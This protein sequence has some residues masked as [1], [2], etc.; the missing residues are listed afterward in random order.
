MDGL[1]D[2]GLRHSYTGKGD[3]ILREFLLP[4]LAVA[5]RYDRITSY[6]TIESLLAIS[7]GIQSLHEHHGTMRLVIGVHSFPLD[8]ADAI[9]RREYL[10]EQVRLVR[11]SIESGIVSISD[12][13][14]RKRI[15]TIAWMI[16]DGLLSVKAAS[17]RGEGIFHPKT[18]IFEDGAGNEVA[19]VGSSNE[20]GSGLGGNF[21]QLLVVSSWE[22][23]DAVEDQ[24]VFFDALW[25]DES[26]DAVVCDMTEE[27]A[28]TLR[29]S[30]GADCMRKHKLP[31][32]TEAVHKA[33]SQAADMPANFF[34]SG[35]VPALY[36]HQERAVIQALSRWPVRVLFADEVGLGKT[37]EVGATLVFLKKYCGVRRVLVLTPKS[38]LVQWQEELSEHFGIEA[39]VYDSQKRMYSNPQGVS[40]YVGSRN[41][42]G[43]ESPDVMLMSAQY[44]RGSGGRKD[45]FRRTGTVLPDV[46][47]L[48]EA[49]SARISADISGKRKATRIYRML[50]G[51]ARQIP[52]VIFATATP[53]QRE[54]EEYHALL[55][56]LGL[57]KAWQN[58]KSYRTSLGLIAS[59]EQPSLDEAARA[60]R[61]LLS[62]VRTARPALDALDEDEYRAL[63]GLVNLGPNADSFDI[64][65]YVLGIWKDLRGVFIKLHPAHLMTVR[66][67]R[68]SLERVGYR[69]PRR[70]LRDVSVDSPTE[71]QLFYLKV[72]EYISSWYF[73]VEQALYPEKKLSTGF[74][75]V[76]YQQRVS[77]SLWSCRQSLLRRLNKMLALRA[78][79]ADEGLI[80]R[81]SLASFEALGDLDAMGEDDL[82]GRGNEDLFKDDAADNID[83]PA[84]VRAVDM[85]CTTLRPLIKRADGLL[86]RYGD[87]KVRTSVSLALEHLASGDQVL[88][89]SRYTD[90]VE[91]LIGEFHRAGG[92]HTYPHGIYI[93]Q[94]SVIVA[95]GREV[96]CTKSEIKSGLNSGQ[97]RLMICSDAAS[98]G[99]N[100]QAAR[101]L[102]NVD[103]P[104]TPARLEQRIG[105]VA[106][107]GQR[108][109]SVEIY[110]VWYP[111]S[112]E[113][114]MYKRIQKR[115]DESTLAIGEYPDV[116][117]DNIKALV[118][119]DIEEESGGD[120][121]LTEIR[122][123]MQIEALSRLWSL[124]DTHVTTS[125][126]VRN[127]LMDLCDASYTC[128][129][130]QLD[131]AL[132]VY[133]LPEG[134]VSLTALDGYAESV[135]LTSEPWKYRDF[136]LEAHCI[137]RDKA[138][139]PAA[140]VSHADDTRWIAHEGI[141]DLI[142]GETV[143]E[144]SF[145]DKSPVMLADASAL[146]LSFAIEC[147]VP[148]RPLFWPPSCGE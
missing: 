46:L 37:F 63:E 107:L 75:R 65:D 71:I 59:G 87:M 32:H 106:R 148:A 95:D 41:P 76:S 74:V 129:G 121:R 83:R 103:V 80:S 60:G 84:L 143:Q 138:G 27:L 62:T 105:R 17:V 49:H 128:V 29:L 36:Q 19:A 1:K 67:T 135:S 70:E 126:Y 9:V 97:V 31:N 133:R 119:D 24:R 145:E 14:V 50:E 130:T 144:F 56:L 48:D 34:V 146:D 38:V 23:P 104:W 122:E 18:L 112:I 35:N 109:S 78:R 108:A 11:E 5:T 99:L 2:I 92:D 111:D 26:D 53:M 42:L 117:A 86:G 20:T 134:D 61:L 120:E 142:K 136:D 141:V 28:A 94:K 116:V 113:A 93:G 124:Q 137:V 6:Y 40:R 66:N 44:A 140:F 54:A 73:S 89:F 85:E 100:L 118:L 81:E 51:V 79:L 25:N 52:H 114:R 22:M 123:S 16:E 68:G 58:A 12:A 10:R 30:L 15:A 55:K 69:F 8:L 33:L 132:R 77:S 3:R 13:L 90:T 43:K 101:V 91:A 64:A 102:I 7:Q 39:W 131:G 88:L 72:D 110:N 139:N 96:P 115:L 4:S 57:P 82:L 125:R 21:E 127:G 45:V 98:E 47:I 147:E